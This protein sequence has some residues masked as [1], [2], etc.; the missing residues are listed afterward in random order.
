MNWEEMMPELVEARLMDTAG[1][2]LFLGVLYVIIAFGIFGTLLMMLKEREY[3]MGVLVAIGMKRWR[4]NMVIW[5]ETIILGLIGTL[6]GAILS[7]PFV[8][9]VYRNPIILGGDMA[10][11]YEQFGFD[12]VIT[13]ALR[14]S[15]FYSQVLLVLLVIGILAIYPMFKIA[16]VRVIEYMR[17]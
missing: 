14:P 7:F 11:A 13:A 10:T 17:H 6:A 2:Y 5:I 9:Y 12:P 16:R 15:I 3:E 4:L 8:L 1:N